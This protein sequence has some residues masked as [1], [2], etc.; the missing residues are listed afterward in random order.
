MRKHASNYRIPGDL[1]Y[2]SYGS[3]VQRVHMLHW[4][5]AE[6]NIHSLFSFKNQNQWQHCQNMSAFEGCGVQQTAGSITHRGTQVG[7]LKQMIFL[8]CNCVFCLVGVF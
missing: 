6:V 7:A 1:R 3:C 4:Q 8:L 2:N 5:M